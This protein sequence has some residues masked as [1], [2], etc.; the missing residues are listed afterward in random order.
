MKKLL[1]A[2]AL[3]MGCNDDTVFEFDAGSSPDCQVSSPDA[4]VD[5]SPDA[6]VDANNMDARP[7]ATPCGHD[8]EACCHTGVY[9]S[10][11][12]YC[13]FHDGDFGCHP[14]T[15]GP[16]GFGTCPGVEACVFSVDRSQYFCAPCGGS[17]ELCCPGNTCNATSCN[18]GICS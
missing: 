16:N 13:T 2:M 1:F 14:W 17:G 12:L 10:G 9:C 5:A 6:T 15:C 7:D 18:S 8:G 3:M 4:T 11:E